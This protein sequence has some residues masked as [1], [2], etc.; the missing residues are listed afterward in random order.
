[1]VDLTCPGVFVPATAVFEHQGTN[2]RLGRPVDDGLS[3]RKNRV[4]VLEAHQQMDGNIRFR[5][6]RIDH[7][8]VS[9][10]DL[11]FFSEVKNNQVLVDG[12]TTFDLLLEFFLVFEEKVGSFLD[13]GDIKDL[14]DGHRFTGSDEIHHE[15]VVGNPEIAESSQAGAWVHDEVQKAPVVG[16]ENLM[17]AESGC[18]SL[19]HCFQDLI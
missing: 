3:G 6:H 1:M 18:I 8:P 10:P 13:I 19:V 7:E 15:L 9:R 12:G 16:V 5:I 11:L 14:A 17:N 2:I 4:L